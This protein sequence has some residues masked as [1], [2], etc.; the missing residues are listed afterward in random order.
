MKTLGDAM[1][2][3]RKPKWHC[4]YGLCKPN[5]VKT[6]SWYED[7]SWGA[8]KYLYGSGIASNLPNY[9]D[10][11]CYSDLRMHIFESRMHASWITYLSL[12][13][14]FFS[15]RPNREAEKHLQKATKQYIYSLNT[16]PEIFT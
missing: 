10:I 4:V 12:C 14:K 7:C 5:N 9:T 15:I 16:C 8:C 6:S 2:K 3:Q 1:F 11:N 13:N